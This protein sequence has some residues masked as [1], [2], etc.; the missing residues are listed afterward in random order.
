MNGTALFTDSRP[1]HGTLA[2]EEVGENLLGTVERRT[3][4][5]AFVGCGFHSS[6]NPKRLCPSG[7]RTPSGIKAGWQCLSE[8]R[9]LGKTINYFPHVYEGHL[10]T[11]P[12]SIPLTYSHWD[13]PG[14]RSYRQ[15][16]AFHPGKEGRNRVTACR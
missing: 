8:L 12:I 6:F 16:G 11:M 5:D 15:A 1:G 9:F 7:N 2:W 4:M 14:S 13:E 10:R 3:W